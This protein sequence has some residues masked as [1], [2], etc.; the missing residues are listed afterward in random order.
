MLRRPAGEGGALRCAVC[1]RVDAR[2]CVCVCLGPLRSIGVAGGRGRVD[3]EGRCGQDYCSAIIPPPSQRCSHEPGGLWVLL[4]PTE[5][6]E[7][8]R[9][10]GGLEGARGGGVVSYFS[11]VSFRNHRIPAPP[12][13][14]KVFIDY[15]V[16]LLNNLILGDSALC[17]HRN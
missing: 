2:L 1:D 3:G 13:S 9:W 11:L 7:K 17:S 16:P 4:V 15:L 10:C 12:S 14:T 5:N 6:G 8:G